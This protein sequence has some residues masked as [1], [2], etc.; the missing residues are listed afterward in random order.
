MTET[1]RPVALRGL[2]LAN[3]LVLAPM[4]GY[5][6]RAQR[7]LARSY[8][9]ALAWTEMISAYEVI[10]PG[11]KT[12][13]TLKIVD[14]DRPLGI[15]I[16]GSDEAMMADAAAAAQRMGCFDAIDINMACPVRK[17]ITRGNGG[18]ML[19]RPEESLK[20]I[21]AMRRS[22]ELPLSIKVRRGFDETPESRARVVELLQG[23]E[24]AGVDS[25]T[26][27]GRTVN[28]IYH[29]QAQWDFIYEMAALLKVPV[30]GSGDLIAAA[31]IVERLR[32]GPVAGVVLA[33]GTIG[34]PWIF[35]DVLTEAA[36]GAHEPVARA[37]RV[38]CMWRQYELLREELGDYSAIRIMRRFGMFYSKGIDRACE[39]R[40]ALGKAKTPTDLGAVIKEFFE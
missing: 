19:N 27:H 2:Q 31:R 36:G 13:K 30:F 35:R 38:E 1:I 11:R 39:A 17:V 12:K 4:A 34:S 40:V 6:H 22:T 9:A 18:A 10:R 14:E 29:G 24:S 28:Q 21:A 37:E 26:I 3:N 15:Q 32:G 7:L 16:F 5:T 25:V 23:A 8:G 33:R 20:L